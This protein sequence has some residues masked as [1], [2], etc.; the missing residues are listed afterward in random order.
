MKKPYLILLA[1]ALALTFAPPAM[2]KKPKLHKPAEPAPA[3]APTPVETPPAVEK[4]LWSHLNLTFHV[5]TALK[6]LDGEVT[7]AGNKTS[8]DL[9]SESFNYGG[10]VRYY[11]EFSGLPWGGERRVP[12]F[13]NAEFQ[14]HAFDSSRNA[15][16]HYHFG[17]SNDTGIRTGTSWSGR[18][19]GGLQ[20][21]NLQEVEFYGVGGLELDDECYSGFTDETSGSGI[22]NRFRESELKVGGYIGV[23]A[24]APLR[25]RYL[26]V[27]TQIYGNATATYLP[28]TSFSGQSTLGNSYEFNVDG[29]FRPDIRV[30]VTI[31]L[32]AVF[33]DRFRF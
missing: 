14:G 6:R 26:P 13:F 5:G 19:G 29:G 16:A 31:P 10:G 1:S 18:F 33:P 27:G 8:G 4:D 21:A 15:F 2:A 3:V 24:R 32:D 9:N 25:F 12:Y 20:V 30:G 28:G 23:E 11:G 7:Y 17:M 22:V